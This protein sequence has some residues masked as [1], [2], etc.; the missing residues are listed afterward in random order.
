MPAARTELAPEPTCRN[1]GQ[2]LPEGQAVCLACGAAHGAANRCPHCEALADVEP[3]SALG[4]RCLVCGGPRIALDVADVTLSSRTRGA[5]TTAGSEQTKH[6]MFSAVGFLLTG[7]GTLSLVIATLVLLT[8]SPGL[9]VT[10]ATYLAALVPVAAGLFAL[11]RA[12]LARKLRGEALRTAQISALGDVQAVTGPLDAARVAQL[13]RL[14]PER[15]ELLLAEA[16]IAALLDEAP[17][18]RLRVEAPPA[19][20]LGNAA[21]LAEAAAQPNQPPARSVRGDTES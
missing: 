18:P 4:F 11:S 14:S 17:A 15:C 5:L 9:A 2:A 1:C 6:V 8:A 19:T 10:L 12:G 7:M 20:V 21:E 13:M 3:H 16:S